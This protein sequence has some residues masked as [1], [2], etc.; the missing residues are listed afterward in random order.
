MFQRLRN[1]GVIINPTKCCFGATHLQFL[2]HHIDRDGIRPLDSKVEVI[3]DFPLPTSHRK[4]RE[5]IGLVN[6]Y[7]RFLPHAT[8]LL[9]PLTQLL[10]NCTSGTKEVKW[11]EITQTAFDTFKDALASATLLVHP[12]PDAQL[13]IMTDASELSSSSG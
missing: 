8:D 1:Y 9:H 13:A 11:T 6:F 12:Q 2:G 7:R 3:R 4:L 10:G 5:F